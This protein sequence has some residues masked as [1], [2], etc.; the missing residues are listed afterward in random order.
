MQGYPIWR[1]ILFHHKFYI[2]NSGI[3]FLIG[4]FFDETA[5]PLNPIKI[6]YL[7][8]QNAAV[9]RMI[10]E[11]NFKWI[12]FQKARNGTKQSKSRFLIVFLL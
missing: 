11:N 2:F 6:F 8:A 1:K 9:D 7:I 3:N 4:C 5:V 12:A 10:F